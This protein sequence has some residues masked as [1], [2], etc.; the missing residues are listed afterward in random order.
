MNCQSRRLL[1]GPMSWHCPIF[2]LAANGYPEYG[3]DLHPIKFARACGGIGFAAEDWA[4]CASWPFAWSTRFS[5]RKHWI[6]S[7]TRARYKCNSHNATLEIGS[8]NF[9]RQLRSM[10]AKCF[11]SSCANEFRYLTDGK[12]FRLE[13][14]AALAQR[15]S[16]T[17]YFWL[18]PGCSQTMTLSISNEGN[19]VPAA[20]SEPAH[21]GGNPNLRN[22]HKGLLL[23][24][25]TFP[26]TKY[27]IARAVEF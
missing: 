27:Q 10:L 16:R 20:D 12:L 14:D 13:N 4:D 2:R 15:N 23:S 11:N 22:R 1:F 17:E 21:S 8:P 9:E 6:D 7:T 5:Y 25:V 3:V 24:G 19:V 18:C 26:E